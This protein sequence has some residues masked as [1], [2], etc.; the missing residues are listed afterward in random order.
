MRDPWDR[1]VGKGFYGV[2]GMPSYE[3][4]IE[5]NMNQFTDTMAQMEAILGSNEIN[6][7]QAPSVKAVGSLALPLGSDLGEI[8]WTQYFTA[9]D[10]FDGVLDPTAAGYYEIE[11]VDVSTVGSYSVKGR[12]T[13]KAGNEGSAKL[14]VVIYN[15]ENKE[16]PVLTV[17]AELPTVAMD[18]DASAID[19]AGS[20]VEAATDADGL[21]I[22]A[23]V[24]ADLTQ[25]DTTTPGE[26]PVV[27][28]V[29][30]Y[31]GNEASVEITV[32]VVAE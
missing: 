8:D 5:A 30:D 23:N 16:A 22:K 2:D 15:A 31:A 17:K 14:P 26:Y 4:A 20:Y 12:F 9:E 29:K 13:D 6:D 11:G 24:S 7:N 19:W 28:S 21:D 10:G 3:V 25:L 32:N 1:I 18:A 27:L